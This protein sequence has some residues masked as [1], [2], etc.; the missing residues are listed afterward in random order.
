MQVE[1]KEVFQLSEEYINKFQSL[2]S[3]DEGKWTFLVN[4]A[5]VMLWE[6]KEE[7]VT[8]FRYIQRKV[9]LSPLF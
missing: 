4:G 3:E 8:N 1:N 6:T 9:A 7:A 5:L 2:T